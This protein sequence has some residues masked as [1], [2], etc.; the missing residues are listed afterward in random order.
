MIDF[1]KLFEKFLVDYLKNNP[2][3]FSDY[4]DME[5]STGI[6]YAIWR[7]T[8]LDELNGNT[9]NKFFSDKNTEELLNMAEDYIKN[10]IGIPMILTDA[11]EESGDDN[12]VLNNWWANCRYNK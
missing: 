3:K 9:P 7:N 10:G 11:L 5:N 8:A 4:E 6:I 12:A 1:D 2:E